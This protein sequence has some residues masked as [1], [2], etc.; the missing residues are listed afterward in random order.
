MDSNEKIIQDS[1]SLFKEMPDTCKVDNWGMPYQ[2]KEKRPFFGQ[3]ENEIRIP[4]LSQWDKN[5][6]PMSDLLETA[7]VI[8]YK[9]SEDFDNIKG[10]DLVPENKHLYPFGSSWGQSFR[11]DFTTFKPK[12]LKAST[13]TVESRPQTR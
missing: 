9:N 3:Y 5:E 8:W 12:S 13:C 11:T 6:K 4:C 1:L 7:T 2:R 10:I